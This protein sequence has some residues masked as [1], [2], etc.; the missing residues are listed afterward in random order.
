[1]PS[2]SAVAAGLIDCSMYAAVDDALLS[3]DAELLSAFVEIAFVGKEG[4]KSFSV[5]KRT[6]CRRQQRTT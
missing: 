6:K 1:M 2:L 5:E 4:A 3:V